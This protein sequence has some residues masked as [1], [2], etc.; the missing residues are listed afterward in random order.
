[1]TVE[2]PLY[3]SMNLVVGLLILVGSVFTVYK[4]Y[5][6]SQSQ[7]AYA[8]MAFTLGYSIQFI[9]YFFIDAFP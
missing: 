1:M 6:G 9:A 3:D 8:L 5:K 4:I 7:F 2:L